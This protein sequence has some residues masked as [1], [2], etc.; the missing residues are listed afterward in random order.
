MLWESFQFQK[1]GHWGVSGE[2]LEGRGSSRRKLD[3]GKS[4]RRNL[5]FTLKM[6]A[7]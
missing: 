2:E 7:S 5:Y 1:T 6:M 4:A 3:L